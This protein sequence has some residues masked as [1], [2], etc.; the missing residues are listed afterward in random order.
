MNDHDFIEIKSNKFLLKFDKDRT[1]AYLT[2]F[3]IGRLVTLDETKVFLRKNGVSN[4][5]EKKLEEYFLKKRF[6]EEI[7][8]A[9]G[10]PV[11]HGENRRLKVLVNL[12][13]EFKPKILED[14]KVD[15]KNIQSIPMVKKGDI[16][17]E[18]LP[19]TKGEDGIDINGNPIKAKDGEN[20]A[21]PLGDNL[22]EIPEKNI[23]VAE[24]SGHILFNE[25]GILEVHDVLIIDGNV[26]YS[27]G[28]IDFEG[29]IIIEGDVKSGF[30]VKAKGDIE[31]KGLVEDAVIETEQSVTVKA[32]FIGKN[33]GKIKAGQDVKVHHIDNEVIEAGN[34]I[35]VGEEII[36]SELTAGRDIIVIGKKGAIIGGYVYAKNK[37]ETKI[38]G[39][40]TGI[41]TILSAGVS[42]ELMERSRELDF[43]IK[44]NQEN[45]KKIKQNLYE[46]VRLQIDNK[47]T[48]EK[49][50]LLNYLRKAQ[51]ALP[52]QIQVYQEEYE[53]I[54]KIKERFKYSYIEV[55]DIVYPKVKIIMG[56]DILELREVFKD[57]IFRL[58]KGSI[59]LFI[60]N[61]RVK[62]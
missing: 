57:A 29:S 5:F 11:K 53:K 1:L 20:V 48:P 14:G 61:K 54:K 17:A 45:L 40:K 43:L 2:V 44:K 49:E 35:I 26:D 4:F 50:K 42:K 36:N 39:A 28:N 10:K 6:N 7:L 13:P 46:L 15:F 37:I 38:A 58:E 9:Q 3:E 19:P 12:H 22:R 62:L 31:I 18:I 34:D 8:I 16:V 60:K 32:G 23:V 27:V 47:L 30:I 24:K 21:L 33:R 59:S 56:E 52:K 25:D 55:K 41:P 51:M